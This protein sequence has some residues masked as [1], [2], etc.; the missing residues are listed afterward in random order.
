MISSIKSPGKGRNAQM[1]ESHAQGVDED[2]DDEELGSYDEDA[3]G[4]GK[5]TVEVGVHEGVGIEMGFPVG[6]DGHPGPEIDEYY[7]ESIQVNM[8][9]QCISLLSTKKI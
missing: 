5:G 7:I 2:A 4:N 1:E 9:Y 3:S 6:H 8:V